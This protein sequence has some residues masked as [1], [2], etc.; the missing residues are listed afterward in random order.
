MYKILT[1]SASC[2]EFSDRLTPSICK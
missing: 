1:L 2:L